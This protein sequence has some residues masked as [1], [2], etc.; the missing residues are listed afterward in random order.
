L[1]SNHSDW[2]GITDYSW[3]F[4]DASPIS[5]DAMPW[6]SYERAG[7]YTVTLTVRDA[8]L[9]GDVSRESFTIIVNNAPVINEIILPDEIRV[10]LGASLK[11]NISDVEFESS[12][13]VWRDLDV[14]DGLHTDH[15]ERVLSTLEVRWEFDIDIDDD[16]NGDSADD[17]QIPSGSD[18]IRLQATWAEVGLK[19]MR[20]EICDGMG[21]C[22]IQDV[23]VNVIEQATEPASLSDFSVQ[24]W[25]NW[26]VDASG[27]SFVILALIA[28]VLL[29]GWGVMRSP[30]EVEEAAEQAAQ[31]YDVDEVE[32]FG[33]VLGMDHHAPPPVPSILSKDERRSDSSGY[34]RPLRRRR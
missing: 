28:A 16:S 32:S 18:G 34:V 6:H 10:G 27:E 4:G 8:Y 7:T 14:N 29:L 26:L 33:G 20:L 12:Y 3:D 31:T 17:W 9:T 23:E 15:D 24:D 21:V 11:A 2:N 13:V 22:V 1:E 5:H 25:K 19:T 30:S